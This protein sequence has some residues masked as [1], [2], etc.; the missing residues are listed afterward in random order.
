MMLESPAVESSEMDW[1]SLLAILGLLVLYL[2]SRA[3]FFMQPLLGEEGIF[4][5][6]MA[7]SP[8]G[9]DYGLLAR[10]KGE[11]L[12]EPLRHPA[13]M[14]EAYAR[15]GQLM[16]G[17]G[18]LAGERHQPSDIWARLL[19]S[20]FQGALWLVLALRFAKV[21]GAA[22]GLL[23]ALA[24]VGFSSAL[25][26]SSSVYLQTDTSTGLLLAGLLALAL[27]EAHETAWP[28]AAAFALAAVGKQEWSLAALAGVA[29]AG[30]LGAM[31]GH[32]LAK[33]R[34]AFFALALAA[35]N[36]L[37]WAFDPLNYSGGIGVLGGVSPGHQAL[38]AGQGQVWSALWPVRKPFVLGL[39]ALLLPA[40][41]LAVKADP[42]RRAAEWAACGLA[43]GLF[44]PFIASTWN[45]SP[46]YFAPAWAAALAC[47][48]GQLAGRRFSRP[49]ALAG[50]AAAL[51][52]TLSQ[53][54]FLAGVSRARVSLTEFPLMP[55]PAI[56]QYQMEAEARAKP[57]CVPLLSSG[58]AWARDIDFAGDALG[59]EGAKALVAKHGGRLCAP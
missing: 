18:A 42:Y 29:G 12:R 36:L 22:L 2:A 45:S 48:A 56:Y 11:A 54:A 44:L 32:G 17:L 6:L 55:V 57:G 30:I 16:R 24:L 35:G 58:Y 31:M 10:V 5:H 25:G 23:L 50:G 53:V 33:R 27:V 15:L 14:Y 4:A 37:S 38:A 43:W 28:V 26:M 46:R 13:L 51:A 21:R 20:C 8:A 1:K 3:P 34:L 7:A 41:W 9:P 39:L 49:A 47:L 40:T 59:L 52:L 19:H